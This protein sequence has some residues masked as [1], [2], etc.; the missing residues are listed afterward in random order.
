MTIAHLK[1]TSKRKPKMRMVVA[2]IIRV[3]ALQPVVPPTPLA[4]A[5]LPPRAEEK[6]STSQ[7]AS[8]RERETD[9]VARRVGWGLGFEEDIGGDYA[10]CVAK[11]NHLNR[12][13][14]VSHE[15]RNGVVCG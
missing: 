3:L 12:N 7:S 11:A 5:I 15:I 4:L 6:S 1:Q 10:A 2:Q 9:A 13:Q 14:R 8:P